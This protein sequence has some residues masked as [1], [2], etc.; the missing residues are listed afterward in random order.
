[1]TRREGPGGR[2]QGQAAH[3]TRPGQPCASFGI[4][5]Q[6]IIGA[7]GPEAGQGAGAASEHE[8]EDGRR[9]DRP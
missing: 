8:Q 3:R 6:G 4:L 9:T 1:M 2:K 7:P 5:I